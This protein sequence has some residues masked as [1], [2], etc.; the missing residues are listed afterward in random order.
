MELNWSTFVLEIINFLILVWILKRFLYKPVME[1]IAK[2]RASIEQ[3]MQAA[4]AK[5][6]AATALK[7]QYENRLG[8]WEQEKQLAREQLHQDIDQ[9]R[10]RLQAQLQAGM[11]QEAEK[12]RVIAD[13]QR[14]EEQRRYAQQALQNSVRFT[15]KLLAEVASP[16]LEARLLT[17]LLA[18]LNT[19]AETQQAQLKQALTQPEAKARIQTAYPLADTQ[20]QQLVQAL[21]AIGGRDIACEFAQVQEL[22]AGARIQIGPWLLQAS[23]QDELQAFAE[24]EH[25]HSIAEAHE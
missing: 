4:T 18:E 25:N 14:Q 3:S 5:D 23:L 16:E 6:Q 13:Q 7:A 1:A 12:A 19:L 2:R 11:Q 15:S 20:R 22:L 24:F 10:Q 17:R 9:E 21:Q 8:E